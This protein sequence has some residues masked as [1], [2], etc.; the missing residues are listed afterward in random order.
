MYLSHEKM[1]KVL[2]QALKDRAPKMYQELKS[3]GTLQEFL[4]GRVEVVRDEAAQAS[5]ESISRGLPETGLERFQEAHMRSM[6][7]HKIALEE[8]IA[9]LPTEE[10]P[11]EEEEIM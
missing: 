6:Q 1:M 3:E 2:D 4:D 7:A 9:A 5:A 8:G 11:E 10:Q